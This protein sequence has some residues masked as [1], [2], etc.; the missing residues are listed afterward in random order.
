MWVSLAEPPRSTA[1]IYS[2]VVMLLGGLVMG[3]LSSFA[4][5]WMYDEWLSK[6]LIGQTFS[7]VRPAVWSI[8]VGCAVLVCP[9]DIPFGEFVFSVFLFGGAGIAAGII[10]LR[11]YKDFAALA[12]WLGLLFAWFVLMTFYFTNVHDYFFPRY[13]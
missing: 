11:L 12:L 7:K 6:M 3:A 9:N 5:A 8:V 10:I 13:Y 4:L 2:N 1:A